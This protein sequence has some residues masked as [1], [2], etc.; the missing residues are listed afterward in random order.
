MNDNVITLAERKSAAQS[1][2]DVRPSTD[3]IAMHVIELLAAEIGFSTA[4]ARVFATLETP[5]SESIGS[6]LI[7][8]SHDNS[9]TSAED[10]KHFVALFDN[11]TRIVLHRLSSINPR[12][13]NDK[14]VI[15]RHIRNMAQ[16]AN[17]LIH[18]GAIK[19]S[20]FTTESMK[21]LMGNLLGK[22]SSFFLGTNIFVEHEI[23]G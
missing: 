11:A 19:H 23:G 20:A 4:N 6:T 22:T 3:D 16:S 17:E 13:A 1:K 7:S 8:G 5:S 15:A 14:E 18:S 21:A 12:I 10:K 2:K 9:E